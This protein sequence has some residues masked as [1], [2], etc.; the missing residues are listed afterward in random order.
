M[1]NDICQKKH[2]GDMNRLINVQ[3]A[4]TAGI[5]LHAI[6]LQLYGYFAHNPLSLHLPMKKYRKYFCPNI[7]LI[8]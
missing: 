3:D 5:V 4:V 1:N 6:V 7:A 8:L 2:F